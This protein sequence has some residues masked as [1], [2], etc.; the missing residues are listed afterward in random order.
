LKRDLWAEV[1]TLFAAALERPDADRDAFVRAE[2]RTPEARRE[3][4]SLLAAHLRSSVFDP[5]TDRQDA[6]EGRRAILAPGTRIGA[7]E[8]VRELGSGGMGAVYLVQRADEMFAQQGALKILAAELV[9][10]QA[11]SRFLAERQI[12]ATLSHPNIAGV[13]D[14]GINADGRPYFVMEYVEGVPIDVHCDERRLDPTARLRLFLA[15][16]DAVQFAHQNL[17]VHRDLKPGN[18]LVTRSGTPKLLDFGIAKVLGMRAV[19]GQGARTEPGARALT[20]DYASPEQLR[21]LVITPASDVYQL[22]LLLGD[23]LIGRRPEPAM[24]PDQAGAAAAAAPPSSWPSRMALN[25]D[26]PEASGNGGARRAAARGTTPKRLSRRLRGDLDAIILKALRPEPER[27]YATA[28]HLAADIARHLRG[29]P[30]LARPDTVAYRAGKFGRR[31]AVRLATVAAVFLLV[32]G[33]AAGMR[34][35]AR[36]TAIERDRAEEVVAFLVGLFKSTDPTF[37]QGDTVTVRQV[38]DRGAVR[39]REELTGQPAVQ[40]T[41]MEAIGEVYADLGLLDPAIKM[42]ERAL[43]LRRSDGDD[44][45][46]HLTATLRSLGVYQTNVGRFDAAAPLLNEALERLRHGGTQG[47]AGY[48]TTLADI[49]YAWQ[50]QGRLETA[51]PLLLEALA[52]YETVSPPPMLDMGAVLTNLG[53]L[54]ASRGDLDSA[55]TLYRRSLELRRQVSG[56]GPSLANSLEALAEILIRR[57]SLA[58]ADSAASEA[59]RIRRTTLPA[60]HFAIAGPIALRARILRRQGHLTS[61]EALSREALAIR[62]AALGDGHFS[63]ADSRNDLALALQAQGRRA[64]AE[65]LFRAALD[66]YQRHFGPDHAKSAIVELNLARIL[67]RRNAREDA[68]EHLAHAVPI[69]RAAYPDDPNLL[70]DLISLGFLRCASNPAG[71]LRDLR[72]GVDGLRPVSGEAAPD[73]YLRALNALGSC[74]AR[75]GQI[76]EARS[77][78]TTSLEQSAA[79]EADDPYRAFA[80]RVL[81]GLPPRP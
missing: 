31:H 22:G 56:E 26:P 24:Q 36:R 57:G 9:S 54:R 11:V 4:L 14:G 62:I 55:E 64:E 49:G 74:L 76:N 50:V 13:I 30:V 15:V 41:L 17:I 21:G 58:A 72:E 35:Q 7:W 8:V 20:P 81:R 69:A 6:L 27:R 2:A 23:L 51:E 48:A 60:G 5:L 25:D 70:G 42:L 44:A 37:A 59:L 3:V 19:A 12:L 45:D 75:Q 61:A 52:K 33:F 29:R 18:L 53:H 40:A 28:G 1:E 68:R 78:L 65:S 32:V 43:A 66:G 73:E 63:V 34:R 79:R 38:L 71:A 16:C 39:V 77:I 46:R 80:L 10:D 47:T 67:F